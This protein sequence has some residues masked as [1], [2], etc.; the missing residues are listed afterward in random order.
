MQ[1]LARRVH[2]MLALREGGR[3]DCVGRCRAVGGEEGR[4][5]KASD[6]FLF[7]CEEAFKLVGLLLKLQLWGYMQ[8]SFFYH[9]LSFWVQK[10]LLILLIKG[11][12][13]IQETLRC[14]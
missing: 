4:R 13:W 11:G 7:E 6:V 2:R 1:C 10:G 9:M 12:Q 3:W 14:M 8:A 5:G